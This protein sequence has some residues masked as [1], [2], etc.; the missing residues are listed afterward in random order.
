MSNPFLTDAVVEKFAA[1][2]AP[3]QAGTMTV[4]GSVL[5]TAL[6]TA[7]VG[8]GGIFSWVF[9]ADA[10]SAG[11]V[12]FGSS[13]AALILGFIIIFKGANAV[14]VLAYALLQGL[15]MGLISKAY[16]GQYAGIVQDAI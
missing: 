9:I 14:T 1:T 5:K 13:I 15:A 4:S 10:P 2:K 6:A 11:L 7:M 12:L 8:L 3:A 16:E